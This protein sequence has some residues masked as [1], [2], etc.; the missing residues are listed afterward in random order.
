[1][2]L[3]PSKDYVHIADYDPKPEDQ[4]H[5]IKLTVE[6]QREVEAVA[7]AEHTPQYLQK[8]I[9]MIRHKISKMP[10]NSR[11]LIL[12]PAEL[13]FHAT[14]YNFL[15][16]MSLNKTAHIENAAK[17]NQEN[18]PAPYFRP[19]NANELA[20]CPNPNVVKLAE[21]IHEMKVHTDFMQIFVPFF[22]HPTYAETTSVVERRSNAFFHYHKA[23]FDMVPRDKFLITCIQGNEVLAANFTKFVQPRPMHPIP[24]IV[25]PT[26]NIISQ[27]ADNAYEQLN[28]YV[29]RCT[30]QDAY[31]D[32]NP[33]ITLR[34]YLN[35]IV[36][37]IKG[38]LCGRVQKD[39]ID[40]ANFITEILETNPVEDR[41]AQFLIV[42]LDNMLFR[43]QQ[44]A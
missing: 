1:M 6:E 17:R 36:Y 5:R 21:Q 35:E 32:T 10:K 27:L 30:S 44:F 16:S 29:H 37:I 38:R 11:F 18:Q 24:P 9:G 26:M 8:I 23:L 20:V 19:T 14:L 41:H 40:H 3:D 15:L 34:D 7:L 28:T 13:F 4:E 31:T 22:I 33:P 43:I 39:L 2:K 42:I 25:Q 12:V